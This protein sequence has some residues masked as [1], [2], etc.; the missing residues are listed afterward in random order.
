MN[1]LTSLQM[2]QKMNA[3]REGTLTMT[4]LMSTP[5]NSRTSFGWYKIFKLDSRRASRK[6]HLHKDLDD[7]LRK[8][9]HD[10]PKVG[11]SKQDSLYF[12]YKT[13]LGCVNYLSSILTEWLWYWNYCLFTVGVMKQGILGILC[14]S[15]LHRNGQNKPNCTKIRRK[16]WQL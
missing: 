8:A 13:R 10:Q 2:K 15:L 6:Q 12:S 9:L 4:Y 3:T 11:Q 1:W 7:S 16:L 14:F 5:N